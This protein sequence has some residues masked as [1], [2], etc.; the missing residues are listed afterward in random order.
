[1][2]WRWVPPRLLGCTVALS[3]ISSAQA[4]ENARSR[5]VTLPDAQALQDSFPVVALVRGITGRVVL[6]C[7]VAPDGESECIAVEETPSG[8]GFATAAESLARDW[9]F[10]SRQ[11]NGAP[12]E[13]IARIPVVFSNPNPEPLVPEVDLFVDATR[14]VAPTN[15]VVDADS[16]TLDRF[17]CHWASGRLCWRERSRSNEQRDMNSR[18]YPLAALQGALDGRA[19][20]ACLIQSGRRP[21]C[22][23]EQEA[24]TGFGFGESA[25][26]L[27]T[28][29]IIRRADQFEPGRA[30]RVPV[31]F[32]IH[33][34]G[35]RPNHS[36]WEQRPTAETFARHYPEA[37]ISGGV[38]G[39]VLLVC[40]I[41]TD[42]RLSCEVAEELPPGRGFGLAARLI[43]RDFLLRETELGQ[44]GQAVGDRIRIPIRFN[45]L[46][47][48]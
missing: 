47:G 38:E 34:R 12:A 5:L 2:R 11:A 1:M 14:G 35:F 43:A 39:S 17:A 25:R 32:E 48:G 42:R 30:F 27:V 28:D 20:V 37:A 13:S 46:R 45:L 41:R 23:L 24:P 26:T 40:A 10:A 4:Q 22:E 44:P 16:D 29:I 3:L 8:M 21:A 33:R 15:D 6:S 7:Q 31:D 19:L 9:R 36:A 18:Y